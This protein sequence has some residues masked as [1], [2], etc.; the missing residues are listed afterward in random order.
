MQFIVIIIYNSDMYVCICNAIKESQVVSSVQEGNSDLD[1]VSADLGV[2]MYCGS[3]V[4][5]V[6]AL[7]DEAKEKERSSSNSHMNQELTG[8]P[9]KLNPA[10]SMLT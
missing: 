5:V 3:C 10:R 4:N 7:I 2:G 1:S 6:K 9:K 8:Q